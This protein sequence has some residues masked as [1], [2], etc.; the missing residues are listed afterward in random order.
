MKPISQSAYNL[1]AEKKY[2]LGFCLWLFDNFDTLVEE[3]NEKRTWLT[4]ILAREQ[5][6]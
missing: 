5:R 6:T 3:Q 2:P 1:E 4:Q